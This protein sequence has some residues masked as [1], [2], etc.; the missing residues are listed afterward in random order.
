M[1]FE[2][3]GWRGR[4]AIL[5]TG[6]NGIIYIASTLPPWWLVDKW[7]RR[8]ILLSGAVVMCLALS[9]I[10]YWMYIEVSYTPNMVVI[11]V[12]IYN[13]FFG[14]SWGPIPWLYPPEIM[15]L[16]IRAKGASLS[17]ATNWAFNWLVGMMTPMLQEWI[18][19]RLYL[20]HAFFCACSFV[21]VYFCYPET[22]GVM[23][24]DMVWLSFL[25]FF[26]WLTKF[27]L[28]FRVWRPNGCRHACY[29]AGIA[30]AP[31]QI[32]QSGAFTGYQPSRGHQTSI[33]AAA[34][35]GA[36]AARRG[37]ELVQRDIRKEI[38]AG[39]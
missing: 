8:P 32:G 29:L 1:V 3:A 30:T 20:V 19:W 36:A 6:I 13:A 10:S 23:L 12:I 39:L 28:G 21:L 5:M 31:Q 38:G 22:K 9:T 35:A 24:E 26:F 25:P 34:T 17:T 14:Y 15:P 11:F 33:A 16:S 18:K 2:Q 27:S 4:D 7:G 37:G